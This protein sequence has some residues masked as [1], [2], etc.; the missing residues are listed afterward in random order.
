MKI[1]HM[2]I[3]LVSIALIFPCLVSAWEL[4]IG[5]QRLKPK[6]GVRK[7]TYKNAEDKTLSFKPEIRRIALGQAMN[8]G[9]KLEDLSFYVE[10]VEY[11]YSSEITPSSGLVGKDTNVTCETKE[12]R[13]GLSYHLER[14]LAGIFAGI[15]ISRLEESILIGDD[16]WRFRTTTPLL[17]YGVDLNLGMVTVRYE[18]VHLSVGEHSVREDSLGLFLIF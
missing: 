17:R 16:P 11:Q 12:E 9:V 18:Q 4:Q 6:L 2:K 7:Q 15:G 13:V 10:R 3:I 8:I 14:E 1:N 5:Y